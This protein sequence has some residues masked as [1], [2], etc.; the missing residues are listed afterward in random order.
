MFVVK[1]LVSDLTNFYAQHK[2]I[3]PWSQSSSD[4]GAAAAHDVP[5]ALE[6]KKEHLQSKEDRLKLDG[7][8][9]CILCACCSTSRPSYWRNS[10]KYLGPA[11]LLQAYRRII[12][13]RDTNTEKRLSFSQDPFK[14]YRC[15][16]ITNRSK[17]CPKN[18]NPG[19]AIAKIKRQML[20][21]SR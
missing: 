16:T 21:A 19:L 11:I 8:Y 15:H 17:T 20:G 14:L 13:S 1:D 12:D 7:L 4:N 2:S 5:R 18:P 10:D 9:E 6:E 3:E